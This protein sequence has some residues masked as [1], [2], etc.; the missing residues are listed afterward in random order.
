L[1]R[2]RIDS[3]QVKLNGKIKWSKS[4][5]DGIV[6]GVSKSRFD[7]YRV[8]ITYRYSYHYH[9]TL[10]P[11]PKKE[12]MFLLRSFCLSI[13]FSVRCERILTKFLGG[14]GHGAGIKGINFGE[15]P[16]HRPDPGVR[17]PKSGFTGLW[18]KYP[19]DSDQSCIA[20]LHC[21]NHPSILLCYYAN[22]INSSC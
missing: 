10:L 12:V 4:L 11:Q 8:L 13:C 14:V 6:T 3:L 21:K 9:M 5:Y 7:L 22:S 16:D 15:D 17:S 1:S 18:K 19:V 20:N 2:L